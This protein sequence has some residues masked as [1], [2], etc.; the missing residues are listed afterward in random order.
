MKGCRITIPQADLRI[1]VLDKHNEQQDT[2]PLLAPLREGYPIG[3]LSD[4]GCPGVAD[5]GARVVSAA[6]RAGIEVI[7][8]IGPSSLLLALMASGLEGQRFCFHGYLPID[9]GER[10][11]KIIRLEESAVSRKET[12]LFIETPYRNNGLIT[13]LL[14]QLRGDTRLCI[15]ADLTLPTQFIRTKKIK[16]WKKQVPDLHKRPA[17]F[18]LGV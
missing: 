2:E 12:Q 4:A 3:L 5:P 6:H 1:S 13:D 17:V 18:L 9:K 14:Q 15:A 7:P 16:E 8:M 10:A 11:K